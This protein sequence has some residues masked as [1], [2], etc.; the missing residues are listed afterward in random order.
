MKAL[1]VGLMGFLL[2]AIVFAASSDVMVMQALESATSPGS[3]QSLELTG[4]SK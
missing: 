3:E 4:T 1:M 2:E